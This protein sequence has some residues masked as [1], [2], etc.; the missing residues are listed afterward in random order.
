MKLITFHQE[1]YHRRC[2]KLFKTGALT[3]MIL[4]C[5][6]LLSF[7]YIGNFALLCWAGWD[8]IASRWLGAVSSFYYTHHLSRELG[9]DISKH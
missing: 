4:T 6:V 8:K 5:G 7:K 1:F 9:I 2:L 3:E